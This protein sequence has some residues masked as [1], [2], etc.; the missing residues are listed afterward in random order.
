MAN[1]VMSRR[2]SPAQIKALKYL[3]EGKAL[4]RGGEQGCRDEERV[5]IRANTLRVLRSLGLVQ[6]GFADGQQRWSLTP[7]GWL[8][9][10]TLDDHIRETAYR[11]S[12][13]RQDGDAVGHW[14]EAE[15]NVLNGRLYGVGR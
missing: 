10:G 11:I 8:Y 15:R 2:L 7:E 6:D 9:M 5:Y 4:A 14:L 12:L 13:E 1:N 3:A